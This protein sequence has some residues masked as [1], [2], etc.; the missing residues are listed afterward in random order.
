MEKF[1][2]HS[3]QWS[4]NY[5]LC[6]G[7]WEDAQKYLRKKW[8]YTINGEI[9]PNANG[10]SHRMISN[11]G[12]RIGYFLWLKEFG[13]SVFDYTTLA[14]EVLHCVGYTLDDLG[15]CYS[16]DAKEVL[17]YT[18]DDVYSTLLAAIKKS[19]VDTLH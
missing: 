18:F 10:L 16:D 8:N 9:S 11:S 15:V 5:I 12:R 2:Y 13:F 19:S 4:S 17:T 14:H 7:S 3:K 1:F 6:I